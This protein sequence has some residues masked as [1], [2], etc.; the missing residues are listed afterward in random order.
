LNVIE[1]ADLNLTS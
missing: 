1:I